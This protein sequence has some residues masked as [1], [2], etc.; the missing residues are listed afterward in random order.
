MKNLKFFIV[1]IIFA[2]ILTKCEAAS[3]YRIF[4]MFYFKSFH[5][6]GII[7]TAI[8]TGIIGLQLFKRNE[9]RDINGQTIVVKDK[10]K[11]FTR[12]IL[13]GVFFGLGWGLVATCPG[14]IFILIGAGIWNVVWVLLGALLG[15]FVYG[16][17]KDKIPH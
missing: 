12:Y 17:I 4:E 8:A 7:G 1:G 11:G 16:V 5:M 6:F 15:T 9:T 13:G 14:P 10:E 2:I 3:W